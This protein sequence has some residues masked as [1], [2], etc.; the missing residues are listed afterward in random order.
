MNFHKPY[1]FV[2]CL[3]VLA[4]CMVV[5]HKTKPSVETPPLPLD[6]PFKTTAKKS[7]LMSG[8]TVTT[9]T[10][11][12]TFGWDKSATSN[13]IGYNFYNGTLTSGN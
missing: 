6:I 13:I 9:N 11:K 12:V 2:S 1:F 8:R 4:G 10:A 7:A 5:R 3:L